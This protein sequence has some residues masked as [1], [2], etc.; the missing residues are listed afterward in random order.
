MPSKPPSPAR[1]VLLPTDDAAVYEAHVAEFTTR[2]APVGED[3]Q[4]LAQALAETEWRLQR[5]PALEMGIYALGRI[6]SPN[7]SPTKTKPYAST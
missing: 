4:N 5:I 6:E 2:L 3:E 1:T 7:C